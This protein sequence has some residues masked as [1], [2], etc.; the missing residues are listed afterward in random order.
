VPKIKCKFSIQGCGIEERED[1]MRI[2]EKECPYRIVKCL[3]A[4]CK[5]EVSLF[6]LLD[7]LQ[8]K[9]L[10]HR[11]TSQGFYQGEYPIK[12]E[13]FLQGGC[14]GKNLIEYQNKKFLAFFMRNHGSGLWYTG[15]Y[16][17]GTEEE[18]SQFKF[19]IN[20]SGPDGNGLMLSSSVSSIDVPIEDLIKSGSVGSFTDFIAKNILDEESKKISYHVEIK[21]LEEKRNVKR[22]KGK[23]SSSVP[24][25]KPKIVNDENNRIQRI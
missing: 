20:M 24:K 2:H 19:S 11:S 4:S 6:G 5:E 13:C 23:T 21:S 16:I 8:S 15:V 10:L 17:L 22:A 3:N 1:V 25:K 12:K 14:W 18:A 9:H 7:H